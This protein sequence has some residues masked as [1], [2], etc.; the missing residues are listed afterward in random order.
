MCIGQLYFFFP[1]P[2]CCKVEPTT[3]FCHLDSSCMSSPLFL[4]VPGAHHYSNVAALWN[5]GP[6]PDDL[7]ISLLSLPAH[8]EIIMYICISFTGYCVLGCWQFPETIHTKHQVH[9]H[10]HRQW[11]SGKVF[12]QLWLPEMLQ[13]DRAH[14]GP[15]LRH[16]ALSRRWPGC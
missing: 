3:W 6:S 15:W 14:R 16:V 7:T 12:P 10:Q 1:I 8:I 13:P 9:L 11:G 4:C 2:P 5:I